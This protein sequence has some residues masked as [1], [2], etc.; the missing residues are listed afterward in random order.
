MKGRNFAEW[1]TFAVASAV[2]LAVVGLILAQVPGTDS[3]PAPLAKV[4]GPA[5]RRHGQYAVPVEV[6]NRG[7]ATAENVQVAATL[8]L[9]GDMFEADQVVDFLAGGESAELEFIFEQ[10]PRSGTL[11]VRVTGHAVP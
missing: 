6:T 4:T 5:E 8:E 1:V 2:V 9:G 10:D 3:P 11:K 7:D